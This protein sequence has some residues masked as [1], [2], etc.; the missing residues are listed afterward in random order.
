MTKSIMVSGGLGY[1]LQ[2]QYTVVF[3]QLTVFFQC[4][5]VYYWD[6]DEESTYSAKGKLNSWLLKSWFLL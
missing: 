2:G 4:I 3:W 6:L 5:H 1:S